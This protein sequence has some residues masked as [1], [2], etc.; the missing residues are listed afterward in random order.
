MLLMW[1]FY[2]FSPYFRY[3]G[4]NFISVDVGEFILSGQTIEVTVY[5][6]AQLI[7]PLCL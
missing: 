1:L 6:N 4:F 2:V 3:V 5:E 7:F